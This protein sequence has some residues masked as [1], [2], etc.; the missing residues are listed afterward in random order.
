VRAD[1][2]AVRVWRGFRA[3]VMDL[4]AFYERLGT[5]FVPATVLMQIEAG[6][7]TYIPTVLGGLDGK[8]DTVPDETAILYWESQATYTDGFK[9]LAVRTYTL[10]H[11]AVYTP[12]SGAAFPVPFAGEIVAEQPYN[13]VDAVVDWM[14]GGTVRHLVGARDPEESVEAFHAGIAAALGGDAPLPLGA[15]VCA[16]DEYLTYWQLDAGAPG[17]AGPPADAAAPAAGSSP[18]GDRVE[19][20]AGLCSWS[21]VSTARPTTIEAGLWDEWPGMEIEPGQTMNLQFKRRWET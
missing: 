6:L 15:I 12:A 20:L 21:H 17:D 13:L 5:V 10:T 1:P 14:R 4:K 9:R 3:P 16:G 11:G 7:D 19:A 8:P 2:L 18:A